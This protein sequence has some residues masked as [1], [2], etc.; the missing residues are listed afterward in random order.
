[1]IFATTNKGKLKQLKNLVGAKIKIE[2]L[3]ERGLNVDI[4]EDG[5][6]FEENAIKK[7][8]VIHKLTG[9]AVLADDSG[10]CIDYFDGWPGVY[11]HRFLPNSTAEER[12]GTIHLLF[13]PAKD[14]MFPGGLALQSEDPGGVPARRP[15]GGR[16]S[17]PGRDRGGPAGGGGRLPDQSP[18]RG[19]IRSPGHGDAGFGDHL[20]FVFR[21]RRKNA[22]GSSDRVPGAACYGRPDHGLLRFA[23]GGS[24]AVTGSVAAEDPEGGI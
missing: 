5:R 23:P 6:T 19:R 17:H 20:V 12:H 22:V 13:R 4:E 15:A 21:H 7:A 11:T 14:R 1:M 8:T 2:G 18:P 3:N 24:A 10:L 16:I 9:E